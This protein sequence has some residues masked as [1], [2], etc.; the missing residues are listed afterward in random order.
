MK[1]III[2]PALG[3]MA[4]LSACG[5]TQNATTNT[6]SETRGRSNTQMET[7]AGRA[8]VQTSTTR[9]TTATTNRNTNARTTTA[10]ASAEVE[11]AREANRQKMYSE[12][13]MDNNQISR[14]ESSWTSEMDTWNRNNRNQQMNAYERA[15]RQD[16]IMRDI[17]NE[18]QL[19]KYQQ[20]ARENANSFGE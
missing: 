13:Q 6:Q 10:A 4:M 16:R 18:Q 12:L 20:W 2:L 15:E 17:L 9:T 8:P 3:L 7:S 11:A 14:Y 1:K 5:G 19:E